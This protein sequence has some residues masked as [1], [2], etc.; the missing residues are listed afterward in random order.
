MIAIL[1]M[2]FTLNMHTT[3]AQ[4]EAFINAFRS[5]FYTFQINMQQKYPANRKWEEIK[6]RAN[7]FFIVGCMLEQHYAKVNPTERLNLY[8]FPDDGHKKGTKSQLDYFPGHYYLNCMNMLIA[9]K[10]EIKQLSALPCG[11]FEANILEGLSVAQPIFI[12]REMDIVDPTGQ[13]NQFPTQ[14]Y[15]ELI[16]AFKLQI[17]SQLLLDDTID[18][19][20]RKARE[21]YEKRAQMKNLGCQRTLSMIEYSQHDVI[22]ESSHEGLSL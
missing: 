6:W 14:K 17:E 22:T 16:T 2:Q 4:P 7:W 1:L 19:C 15:D 21:F 13:A 9:R 10:Q 12:G 20:G 8:T 11:L 18:K 3:T 5:H